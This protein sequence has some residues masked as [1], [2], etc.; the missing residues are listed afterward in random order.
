[1]LGP[2]RRGDRGVERVGGDGE[3]LFRFRQAVA[4]DQ[5]LSGDEGRLQGVERRRSGL[6]NLV[7]A[8]H[9]IVQRRAPQGEPCAEHPDGPL[10]P[11]TRLAPVGA[12]RIAGAA[13][14]VA[15]RI[16][17]AADEMN[18]RQGIEHSPRGLVKLNRAPHFEGAMQ[19]LLRPP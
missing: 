18:L 4:G 9:G 19:R 11:L 7:H 16:V 8:R 14:E 5:R 2:C 17:A 6:E 1:V 15:R 12:E 3:A 13:E 10:V